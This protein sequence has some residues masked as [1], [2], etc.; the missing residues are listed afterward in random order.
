M[1]SQVEFTRMRFD[2][3]SSVLVRLRS[4][5]CVAFPDAARVMWTHRILR[6]PA[7][8]QGKDNRNK[9]EL[10]SQVAAETSTTRVAAERMIDAV[11]S[12][13][14]DALARDESAAIAGLGTFAVRGRAARQ[15]RSPR[16][17]E[18]VAVPASKV[19]SFKPTKALRDAVNQ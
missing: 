8:D 18:P 6:S 19:P 10:V 14:A 5:G 1:A 3:D 15:G 12:T 4:A 7:A 13:I 16:T 11:F 17:G 9:A 2:D